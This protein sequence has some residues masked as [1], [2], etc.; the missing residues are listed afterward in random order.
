MKDIKFTDIREK[1]KKAFQAKLK[2]NPLPE[3]EGF[4]IMEGFCG[5]L[6][7]NSLP[8]SPFGDATLPL[9]GFVGKESGRVYT[10]ALKGLLPDIDLG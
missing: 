5:V 10:Y 4:W 8:I 2:F 1:L 3:N 9:V 6:L 7:F